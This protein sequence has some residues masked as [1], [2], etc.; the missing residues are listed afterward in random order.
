MDTA[1]EYVMKNPLETTASYPYTST[2]GV[3]GSC[4]YSAS[5]A[6]KAVITGYKNVPVG[7]YNALKN[8][9]VGGPVSVA[10]DASGTAFQ[11]YTGGIVSSAKCGTKLDHGILAVG[12]GKN[13]VGTE[14]FLVKNQWGGSWGDNGYIKIEASAD[15]ACGILSFPSFVTV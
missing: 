7:D 15:N 10:V 14:F 4:L 1:F 13:S 12:Y 3:R 11:Y 8:A 5:A 2:A 9:L 6:G